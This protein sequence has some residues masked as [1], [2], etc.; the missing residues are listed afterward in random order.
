MALKHRFWQRQNLTLE[1]ALLLCVQR[2][3]K[4]TFK[5][6]IDISTKKPWTPINNSHGPDG[7]EL[8]I[9]CVRGHNQ[10]VITVVL[11]WRNVS[12]W[13]KNKIN[14]KKKVSFRGWRAGSSLSA[15]PDELL[16]DQHSSEWRAP[17]SRTGN[18]L[19][20]SL[21]YL[22][23]FHRRKVTWPSCE[24]MERTFSVQ[25]NCVFT[26]NFQLI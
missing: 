18:L 2:E 10:K 9:W 16:S 15:P 20:S 4:W 8:N 19:F 25:L 3:S 24:A 5:A 17:A 7:E 21:Q 1:S 11:Q 14:Q 13:F 6:F 12:C 26:G 23:M 22:D